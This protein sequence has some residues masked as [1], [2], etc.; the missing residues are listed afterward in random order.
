ML[1]RKVKTRRRLNRTRQSRW[2]NKELRLQD[3]AVIRHMFR[4]LD[5]S[6]NFT[7]ETRIQAALISLHAQPDQ[8]QDVEDQSNHNP[9]TFPNAPLGPI[10]SIP[11]LDVLKHGRWTKPLKVYP[12]YL[13]VTPRLLRECWNIRANV[14]RSLT[15]VQLRY[16][17]GYPA[18]G[19]DG[20][21]VKKARRSLT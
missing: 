16:P 2:A 19:C 6:R 5:P 17:N 9:F 13:R 11:I 4:T 12:R 20:L 14:S 1:S 18:D 15:Q 7:N 8:F 21:F 10:K 3:K